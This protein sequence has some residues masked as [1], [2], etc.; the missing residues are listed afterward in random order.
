MPALAERLLKHVL[1]F[2]L[3]GISL[4]K[5]VSVLD[6]LHGEHDAEVQRIVGWI[7]RFKVESAPHVLRGSIRQRPS[8]ANSEM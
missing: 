1:S 6:P 3:D 2:S 5:G 4:P 7:A 8:R